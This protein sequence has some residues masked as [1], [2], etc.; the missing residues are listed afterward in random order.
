MLKSILPRISAI[1][2]TTFIVVQP[3]HS[4][5]RYNS[6]TGFWEGNICMSSFGWGFVPFQP[7]GSLCYFQANN[8]RIYQ[9][10]IINQ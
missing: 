10:I 4:A 1:L 2:L 5:V 7:I 8:G 9:G 3:T 6:Y